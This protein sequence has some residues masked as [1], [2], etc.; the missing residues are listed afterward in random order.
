MSNHGL[1]D[2]LTA[3]HVLAYSLLFALL[4]PVALYGCGDWTLSDEIPLDPNNVDPADPNEACGI[5][6][7][8]CSLDSPCCTT[9]VALVCE[10]GIEVDVDGTCINPT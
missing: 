5:L 7:A 10:P 1:I 8:A 3:K 2:G 6:G 4:V 9:P